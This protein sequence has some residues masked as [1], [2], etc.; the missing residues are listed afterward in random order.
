MACRLFG[1]KPS[2]KNAGLLSIGPLR[3]NLSDK[4]IKIQNFS[5][6]KI[7]PKIS[8]GKC[9]IV[10]GRWVNLMGHCHLPF[11][12]WPSLSNTIENRRPYI[13]VIW[14][15]RLTPDVNIHPHL[16]RPNHEWSSWRS[17]SLRTPSTFLPPCHESELQRRETFL[18][19]SLNEF[20]KQ[21]LG[22]R[23]L[24]CLKLRHVLRL[25]TCD[26]C[27]EIVKF[28]MTITSETFDNPDRGNGVHVASNLIRC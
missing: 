19:E 3:T 26:N 23:F 25:G 2:S 15:S 9:H 28:V 13:R 18:V 21:K 27:L 16:L 12:Q 6:T 11:R 7:Y 22:Y 5:F 14:T 17:Y 8:S 4:L 1:T 24:I 10:R 20:A